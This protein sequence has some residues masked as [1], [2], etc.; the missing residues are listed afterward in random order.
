MQ[1]ALAAALGKPGRSGASS[2]RLSELFREGS[3]EGIKGSI[4][5][6][7]LADFVISGQDPH[8]GDPGELINIPIVK[9]VV[10]GRTMHEA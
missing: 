4:T 10:G 9:A 8:D 3:E 5:E 6:G 2:A 7:K 1:H